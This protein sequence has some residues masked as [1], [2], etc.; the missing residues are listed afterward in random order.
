MTRLAARVPPRDAAFWPW[1]ALAAVVLFTLFTLFQRSLNWDEYWFLSQVHELDQQ[2]L[3]RPLQT[4]HTRLFGWLPGLGGNEIDAIMAGRLAMFGCLLIAATAV[5][6]LASRFAGRQAGLFAALAYLAAGYVFQHGYSFRIDP[7]ATA[8]LMT[9]LWALAVLRLTPL[10]IAAIGLLIGVAGMIT[11]KTVLYA[12]AF[13]GIAWLRWSEAGRSPAAALRLGAVA[14]ASLAW[15]ALIYLYH[16]H[17]LARSR[18]GA[19]G[20]VLRTAFDHMFALFPAGQWPMIR[21]AISTAPLQFLLLFATPLWLLR[22]RGGSAERVALAGLLAPLAALLY[23]Q[24]TA[25]YFFTFILAPAMVSAAIVVPAVL[26]RYGAR[27]FATL[28]AIG[29]VVV[30]LAEPPSTLPAQRTIAAAGAELF[31]RPIGYFDKMGMLPALAKQNTF[32]T[33]W[34]IELYHQREVP[35]LAGIM[36]QTAVPLVVENDPIF[37]RAL[38]GKTGEPQVYRAEDIAALRSSYVNFWGPFWLAGR[39]VPAGAA[40]LRFDLLVPGPYTVSGAPLVIDGVRHAPGSVVN[41]ARGNHTIGGDRAAAAR[42]IWGDNLQPP[43]LA[44]PPPPWFVGF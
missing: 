17:D 41:L 24:N 38:R 26:K 42:L 43:N 14:L 8:V 22:H 21:K 44:P 6:G 18:E 3:S 7:L 31:S 11:I 40:P 10:A 29:P 34:G 35:G 30:W 19:A 36:A 28:L 1:A 16:A 32:M 20:T 25:A 27:N 13:A 23:Y 15:F 37:T 5:A 4:L 2:R 12:P 33:N 9:S 39:D